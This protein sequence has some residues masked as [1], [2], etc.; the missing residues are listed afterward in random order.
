MSGRRFS[1]VS[2]AV[3]SIIALS[4]IEPALAEQ[5]EGAGN[6]P[7]LE[8]P[9]LEEIVVTA[10]KRAERLLDVPMTVDALQGEQ[11]QNLAIYDFQQLSQLSPGLVISNESSRNQTIQV[12]GISFQQYSGASPG[13]TVYWNEVEV[14]PTTALRPM[15]DVSQVEVLRGAQGTLRGDTSPAG[16]ITITTRRPALDTFGF[17]VQQNVGNLSQLNTQGGVSIPIVTGVLGLR[18]AGLYDRNDEDGVVNITNGRHNRAQTRAG[19]ATLEFKPLDSL[20]ALLVYQHENADAVTYAPTAGPGNSATFPLTPDGPALRASDEKATTPGPDDFHHELDETALSVRWDLGGYRVNYVGSYW[21]VSDPSDFSFDVNN[22]VPNPPASAFTGTYP[23][24]A[25]RLSRNTQRQY[26]SELRFESTQGKFWNFMFGAYYAHLNVSTEVF[27]GSDGGDTTTTPG[28]VLDSPGPAVAH[29]V[30]PETVTTKALFTDQRFKLTENDLV[31]VGLRYTRYPVSRDSTIFLGLTP[32]G[33][34]V[35]AAFLPFACGFVPGATVG[36]GYCN[37]A[38]VKA[39]P[40]SEAHTNQTGRSGSLSYSHHFNADTMAYLSYARSYRPGGPVI[41]LTANLPIQFLTFQ[42]ETSDSYEIGLKTNL[43]DDRLQLF[44]DV[45]HQKYKNFIGTAQGT[46]YTQNPSPTGAPIC[47]GGTGSGC[48]AGFTT[49]GPAETTG[50][51]VTLRTKFTDHLYTQLNLAYADAHYSNADL[52]CNDFNNTGVPN[53]S[54]TP[55]VQPNKYVSTCRTS[56]SLSPTV[57]PWQF[58]ANGEYSHA[59]TSTVDG[60]LRGLV[61]F[62]SSAPGDPGAGL[63]IPATTTVNGFL[64]VRGSQG[65]HGW[66]GFLYV[67]NMFDSR[68]FRTS[69]NDQVVLGVPTG[70]HNVFSTQPRQYGLTVSYHY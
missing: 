9:A 65:L 31:D 10:Q 33:L 37:L 19:R 4:A 52:Y 51:E 68:Y 23:G 60:Y 43:F 56:Q 24:L 66:E 30:V 67:R 20:D 53:A 47:T 21:D 25:Q 54:G 26:T 7:A 35:P 64:G 5:P 32:A 2:R 39:V 22:A 70:Y 46:I 38:P 14:S 57:G 1:K 61:S 49:N 27:Q 42:P 6:S 63:A 40:A 41:G 36:G 69:T 48:N 58:S 29:V 62:S 34:G 8:Q 55:S 12:R 28:A 17:D 45:F 11:L 13:V 3:A 44:A 59:L 16:Q 50:F 15:F 18:L